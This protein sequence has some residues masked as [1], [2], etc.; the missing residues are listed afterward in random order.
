AAGLSPIV[1]IPRDGR[2]PLSFAQ[3]GLWFLDRLAP[4]SALYNMPVVLRIDGPLRVDALV[5]AVGEIARRHEALRTIFVLDG[6]EP[7]QRILRQIPGL[8]VVDLSGLPDPRAEAERREKEEVRR[9]FSLESGPLFRP[10]LL[11]LSAAEH[12]LILAAHHIVTDGWSVGVFSQELEALYQG[13]PLPEPA[14]QYAD[15][16]AWQR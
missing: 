10:L 14:V 4:A 6:D 2:I 1:P 7:A 8:A 12:W 5:A 16:S 9:P 13:S 11:R 3:H 15:F